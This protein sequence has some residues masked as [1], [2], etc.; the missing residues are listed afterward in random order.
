MACG[1]GTPDPHP[2]PSSLPLPSADAES[3]TSATGLETALQN[4]LEHWYGSGDIGGAVVGIGLADGTV[5]VAATGDGSP[6]SPARTDDTMRIGSITKTYIAALTLHLDDLGVLDID[7]AVAS[8]LPHLGI[9]ETVT[10]RDLLAH[11]SGVTDGDPEALVASIRA[12]PGQRFEFADLIELADIPDTDAPRTRDFVYANA[13]YHLVGGVIEAATGESVADVLRA[14][15]LDP[16]GLAST[17]FAGVEEVPTPIVPGNIDLD[18][19]GREDTLADI[20]YL[21]VESHAWT[22]GALVSTPTDL[23]EFARHLFG[24]SILSDEALDQMTDT[25]AAAHGHGLGIFDL[26]IDGATVY[27]NSGGG[28]GFHANLAH[29]PEPGTTALVFTNCPTCA[30]GGDDTHDLLVDLLALA[31]KAGE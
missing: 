13:N 5:H 20:P 25:S 2:E 21:A 1:A 19:D 8:Y 23:I 28:P 10:V 3:S 24:G 16:A 31:S 22:A 4:T 18:G 15:I 17:Y 7:H 11:T 27:G 14:K 29:A 12:E 26:G 6:A 30:V 9:D